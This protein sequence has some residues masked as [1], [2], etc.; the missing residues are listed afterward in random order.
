MERIKLFENDDMELLE[1]DVNKFLSK[2]SPS[3]IVKD[4]HYEMFHQNSDNGS[5]E[6]VWT[7]MVRY[8]NNIPSSMPPKKI[9]L[10]DDGR[11]IFEATNNEELADAIAAYA[12]EAEAPYVVRLPEGTECVEE[13]AFNG[14]S[15]I[16]VILF[17]ES[18]KKIEMDAFSS[19]NALCSIYIPKS[20][21][22]MADAIFSGCKNIHS[23]EVSVKNHKYDSRYDCNAIIETETNRLICGCI[24]TNIPKDVKIIADTAFAGR[25]GLKKIDIP[26]SVEIIEYGAFWDCTDLTDIKLSNTLKKIHDEAFHGCTNLI[27]INIPDSVEEIEEYA[28]EE[29]YNLK[30]IHIKNPDLLSNVD[31][32]DDVKIITT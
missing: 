27:C 23:I 22:V 30:E 12:G 5:I 20:V 7:A 17:P 2:F 14:N 21:D 29:C 32:S 25:I 4:I 6:S 8:E 19:C 11:P 31:L 1:Q 9:E 28:F 26:D 18:V 10:Y 16:D 13:D 3:I 15:N 24:N